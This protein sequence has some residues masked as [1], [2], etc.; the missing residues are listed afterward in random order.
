MEA[1]KYLPKKQ[2]SVDEIDLIRLLFTV[3]NNKY[4]IILITIVFTLFSV[5]YVFTKTP[6]YTAS[7]LIQLDKQPQ[8]NLVNKLMSQLEESS[9]PLATEVGILKSRRVLNQTIDQLGL[10]IGV[11]EKKLPLIGGVLSAFSDDIQK[12]ISVPSF[13]VPP[14]FEDRAWVLT[15]L[16][17]SSY[18]LDLGK[19]GVLSGKVNQTLNHNGF[20]IRVDNIAA[21]EGTKFIL[22]HYSKFSAADEL[23]RN[24]TAAELNKDSGLLNISF[25]GKDKQQI[26]AILNNISMNFI[27]DN[28]LRRMEGV[29]KRLEF[30]N[31]L[32]PGTQ[33]K[34]NKSEIQ[35]HDFQEENGSIDLSLEAKSILDTLVSIKSQQNE[36]QLEKVE[37]SKKYTQSHPT[38]RALLEKEA[39]LNKE[40]RKLSQTI[41]VMPKKQQEILSIKRDVEVGQEIYMQLLSKQNELRITKASTVASMRVVDEAMTAPDPIGSKAGLIIILGTMVGFFFSCGCC[42]AFHILRNPIEDVETIEHFG[43]AVLASIPLS[44]W[45]QRKQRRNLKTSPECKDIWL[46]QEHPEELAIEALRSLRTGIFIDLKQAGKN[47]LSISGATQGAGKTFIC[48][49]LATVMADT[50]KR[51]LLIDADLR[52]GSVHSLLGIRETMGLSDILQGST[53][54]KDFIQPTARPCLDAIS[55]G[56][57]SAQSSELLMSEHFAQLLQWAQ[58][59]YDY[60]IVDTPPILPIT[61]AAIVAQHVG[62]SLLVIRYKTNTSR[63]LKM[64]ISRFKKCNVQLNGVVFNGVDKGSSS[65]YEYG[66]Y[67]TS[68]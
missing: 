60:V 44:K 2:E 22:T 36:L 21:P 38:Y 66:Y 9:L 41:S 29:S 28:M 62:L 43:V 5:L 12:S 47:S 33:E 6:T 15:V 61:D 16:S 14:E 55:R 56:A 37:I 19:A 23:L 8:G 67:S 58:R 30:V 64:A 1:D 11:R 34:L 65:A 18:Q 51:I 40:E 20:A 68:P 46:A 13:T 31:H 39:L 7:V 35:L 26:T 50:G 4:K 32:L 54:F 49:N 3:Y 25:I 57:V 42:L 27:E 63:E 59:E 24:L 48:T 53:M 17:A 45:A 52:L 10:Q